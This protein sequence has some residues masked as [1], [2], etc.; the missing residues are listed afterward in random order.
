MITIVKSLIRFKGSIE[1][2][3]FK[4]E[5]LI[6][7]F[8]GEMIAIVFLLLSFPFVLPIPM[9]GLSSIFG[10]AILHLAFC[11]FFSIEKSIPK[12]FLGGEYSSDLLVKCCGKIIRSLFWFNLKFKFKRHNELSKLYQRIALLVI[13]LS[14]FILLLPLPPGTNLPPALII[15]SQSFAL[16]LRSRMLVIL[17]GILFVI[18][19]ILFSKVIAWLFF[20]L[21]DVVNI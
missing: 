10:Y 2:K 17:F 7:F 19:L 16:M 12:R 3:L 21:L 15:M 1:N 4:L 11:E 9:P 5:D 14:A 13:M 20:K 8:R 18:K 6:N